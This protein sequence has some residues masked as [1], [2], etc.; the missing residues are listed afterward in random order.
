[1]ENIHSLLLEA[2]LDCVGIYP[3]S[4]FELDGSV[5]L[6]NEWENGWNA[7]IISL[8]H[9]WSQLCIWFNTLSLIQ[10]E[11]ISFLLSK[12]ALKLS[13]R[14]EEICLWLLMND[15]FYYASADG[16]DVSLEEL[17]VVLEIYN[18]YNENGLTAW[19]AHKR[20]EPPLDPLITKTYL[21]AKEYLEEKLKKIIV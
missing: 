15:T 20:N 5:K 9:N 2:A 12:D 16:E 3:Q 21:E 13:I 6:R 11:T 17:P 18:K 14:D 8:T 1:M 19:V 7:A 4:F 10:K